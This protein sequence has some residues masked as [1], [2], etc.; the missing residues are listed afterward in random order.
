MSYASGSFTLS[1]TDSTTRS[2]YSTVQSSR[3]A[4]RSSVEWIMEGPSNGLLS[5]FGSVSFSATSATINNTTG[6]LGSFSGADP[7]TMITSSGVARATPSGVSNGSS[8]SVAWHHGWIWRD[9]GA[10]AH[11]ASAVRG[12]S[13]GCAGV[14]GRCRP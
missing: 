7:I 12:V 9:A 11:G 5:D 8:F 6:A 1:L 13:G 4:K 3:K 10:G 2:T 14:S